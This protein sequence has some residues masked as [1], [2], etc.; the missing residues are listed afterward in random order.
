MLLISVLALAM[1][2]SRAGTADNFNSRTGITLP[3]VKGYLQGNCWFFAD[4]DVNRNGWN[5]NME[6]DG[7]MVSGMGAS[8]TEMTGIYTPLL[9][10]NGNVSV[11]FKYKFNFPLID[12]RWL[13]IYAADANAKPILL[14]DS[15]ELTG[16]GNT[17]VFTYH[18]SFSTAAGSLYKL[19]I[20]YQGIGGNE[21]IAIDQLEIS[22]PAHYLSTCNTAP[23]ALGD[24]FTGTPAHT[25]TGN[26]LKN[27]YDANQETLTAYLMEDSPDG[28][29]DLSKDGSFVFSPK[30]GFKG[31]S[32]HFSYKIC[33]NGYP[34]LCSATTTAT[35]RFLSP[36]SSLTGFHAQYRKNAVDL[37]WIPAPGNNS[38]H[39]DIERSL[40]GNNFEK[41]GEVKAMDNSYALMDYVFTDKV[42]EGIARK[43]DLYY[44]LRQVDAAE[45]VFY[46]K[47]LIVR[48]YESKSVTAM[49]VTPDPGANDIQ[50]NVQL[51]EK[52]FVVMKV[53]DNKG[54]EIIKRTAF[55]GFGD[56]LYNIDGTHE[57]LPGMYKLEVIINSNER[58][59]LQLA[60][61]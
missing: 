10:I 56:N 22:A 43:N 33:D 31:S 48:M 7:A 60:K 58:M 24:K 46:S 47:V 18:K 34:S 39:F 23:V 4:F 26:V 29:I 17:G 11:S 1:Q 50:V 19:Y 30:P 16:S 44:R 21:R 3:E 35:I 28:S 8:A 6:G 59:T 27:D 9:D 42:R 49:T 53:M 13:K 25:A 5:P 20:N 57:L 2:G 36:S 41:V 40:D 38:T 12:R 37:S 14:L 61:S 54:S 55:G 45:R 52:S 32:T 15:L 51:K